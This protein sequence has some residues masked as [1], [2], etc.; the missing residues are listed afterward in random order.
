MTEFNKIGVVG[1][2]AWG[3]A[4]GEAMARAGRD[5]LLWAFEI[6]TISEINEFHTNRNYLPGVSLNKSIRATG[7]LADI[8]DCD[9]V[10]LVA[11]A[12]HM[13]VIVGDLSA[14]LKDD[15]PLI[16]CAKGI[17]QKTGRL[18]SEVV[19]EASPKGEIMVLSGPSFAAEVA[20]GLPAAVTLACDDAE[21]GQALMNAIGHKTFRPYLSDDLIGVQIGGALKNV[22]AIAAGIVDGKEMG[23]S[24]HAALVTR[25]FG[26]LV[27]FGE[28]YGAKRD[29]MM[30]L[31]GY[32]DLLLT[33]S[34]HQSRN[35]TL[36]R[37]L[38]QGQSLEEILG[39]R[40]SVTEGVY[41]AGIAHRMAQDK[42]LDVPIMEAVYR[43]LEGEVSVDQAIDDLLTRPFGL[44]IEP[45]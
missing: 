44:E 23:N 21:R 35:M 12:Q 2:G 10:L 17:E 6:E 30:G 4:L 22:L 41:S 37:A 1:G 9:A 14:H 27:Q 29:T 40:K 11:P 20:R 18:M 38:G 3:T 45:G 8:A 16:I 43:V 28:A 15:I 25:G 33:C 7:K 31:S 42:G 19:R 32:G 26:E 34:S 24:A 39:G 13:G 5:V 36:G